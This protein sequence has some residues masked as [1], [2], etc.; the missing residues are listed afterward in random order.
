MLTYSSA[1]RL[2]EDASGEQSPLVRYPIIVISAIIAV[3]VAIPAIVQAIVG[4]VASKVVRPRRYTTRGS[5]ARGN[6]AEVNTDEGEL[7]GSDEE[8]EI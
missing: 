3:A 5:F 6:Y 7:L 1:I 2:G 4:W 8:D